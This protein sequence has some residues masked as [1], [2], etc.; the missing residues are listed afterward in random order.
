MQFRLFS[1]FLFPFL[2]ASVLCEIEREIEKPFPNHFR[3]VDYKEQ[4]FYN[5]LFDVQNAF[6]L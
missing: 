3:D 4:Q 6:T 1:M 5:D 2:F